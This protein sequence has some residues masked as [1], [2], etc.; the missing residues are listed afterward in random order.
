MSSA[1][2]RESL[3]LRPRL[4]RDDARIVEI[5]NAQE[6]DSAPL[7]L[8]IYREEQVSS[9]GEPRSEQWVAAPN[10]HVLGSGGFSPAWWTGDAATF[11]MS[12]RVD[13]T[14]WRQGIGTALFELLRSRVARLQGARLLGWV[15]EDV[16]AGRSFAARCGFQETEK[17]MEE[18][19]L[20]VPE[21]TT[22][23]YAAAEQRLRREGVRIVSLAE[24]GPADEAFL[25]ALRRLWSH[26][27]GEEVAG[28]S[29]AEWR[30]NVLEGPGQSPE[31]HWIALDRERPVGTTFLKRL[32]EDAAENDFTGVAVTHRGRGIAPVLKLHA[33]AWAR[34]HGVNWF[35]TASEVG[36][37]PM[38]T[39][40]RRLGYQ[41]G[42]KRRE[43]A[44]ELLIP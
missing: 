10:G 14:Q 16:P 6:Q 39:I 41:P 35:Y 9:G 25:R 21:A 17:V 32:S 36:N 18:Y 13:P 22:A 31:T 7:S 11:L 3:T 27:A 23:A 2:N 38:V 15:R 33:I 1:S 26:W 40:N 37:A 20:H 24:L 8:E 28:G 4:P 29:L 43:M 34:A 44:G 42:V 5:H 30:R 19:R 12:I